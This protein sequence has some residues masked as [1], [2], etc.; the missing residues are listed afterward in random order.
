MRYIWSLLLNTEITT[1]KVLKNG[2][3]KSKQPDWRQYSRE[4]RLIKGSHRPTNYLQDCT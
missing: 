1:Y 3:L 4:A 2:V